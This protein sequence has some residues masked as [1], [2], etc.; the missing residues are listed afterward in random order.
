MVSIDR[1]RLKQRQRHKVTSESSA[2]AVKK[3]VK[4]K[5]EDEAM[6][7]RVERRK[8]VGSL[9]NKT[10]S[11]PSRSNSFTMMTAPPPSQPSELF[12]HGAKI[13]INMDLKVFTLLRYS[14]CHQLS[15]GDQSRRRRDVSPTTEVQLL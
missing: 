9:G 8:I 15:L 10:A 11:P 14:V 2:R 6:V 4:K 3:K 13:C 1:S 5:K 7:V 12:S